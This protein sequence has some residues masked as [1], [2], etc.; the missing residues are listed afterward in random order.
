MNS[1]SVT[2]EKDSLN[3]EEIINYFN[4]NDIKIVD[5]STED[6]DLEDVC[7]VNKTLDFI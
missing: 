6:G 5:I 4:N 1:I 7:A 3:L 2:Y